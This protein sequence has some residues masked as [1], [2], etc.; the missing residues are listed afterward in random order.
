[1]I[2]TIVP[3][4]VYDKDIGEMVQPSN[5]TAESSSIEKVSL[6]S[7]NEWHALSG[8][9]ELS[10]LT[11]ELYRNTVFVG[12]DRGSLD[13]YLAPNHEKLAQ[14]NAL[15]LLEEKV[16]SLT[17]EA[18]KIYLVDLTGDPKLSLADQTMA[19]EEEAQ[20]IAEKN[21]Q[22][23]PNIMLLM[24]EFGATLEKVSRGGNDDGQ[25]E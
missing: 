2:N 18:L 22:E 15:E 11:R 4:H 8:L 5:K 20:R 17:G 13:L 19:N 6:N 1:L 23:D 12:H 24:N 9:L 16:S 14:S 3:G 7:N 25:Q 21:M 10:G